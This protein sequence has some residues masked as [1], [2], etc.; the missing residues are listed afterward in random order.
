MPLAESLTRLITSLAAL[1][2]GRLELATIE[3]EEESLRLFSALMLSLLALFC[4]TFALAL[5]VVLCIVLF[6]E[7]HRVGVLLGFIAL[8]A[9][10]CLFLV[11]LIRQQYK[12]KPPLLS[13]TLGEIRKDIDAFKPPAG[14][15][16]EL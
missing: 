7:Q 16:H 4:G 13:Y 9:L 2:H 8:F 1:L 12:H 15:R 3:I 10:G 5:L 6:W 11:R 14:A